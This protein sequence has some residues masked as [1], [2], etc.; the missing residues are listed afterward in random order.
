MRRSILLFPLCLVTAVLAGC[1]NKGPLYM[2]PP[3]PAPAP[4]AAKVV[5]A[6]AATTAAPAQH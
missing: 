1:G 5:P 2:P 3:K 6:P 4:T